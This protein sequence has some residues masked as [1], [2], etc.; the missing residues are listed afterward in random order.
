MAQRRRKMCGPEAPLKA[1]FER[2]WSQIEE[3]VLEY[4]WTSIS[5][6]GKS[7]LGIHRCRFK[8]MIDGKKTKFRKI[9]N[10]FEKRGDKWLIVQGHFSFP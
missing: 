1:Q 8:S 10:V 7:S 2:D 6:A 4:K 9:T 5:A 3:P